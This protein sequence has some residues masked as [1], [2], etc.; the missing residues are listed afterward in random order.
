MLH[1]LPFKHSITSIALSEKAIIFPLLTSAIYVINHLLY[2]CGF[3]PRISYFSLLVSLSIPL[4]LSLYFNILITKY[5]N[6]LMYFRVSPP[7]IF[8]SFSQLW[9]LPE[10]ARTSLLSSSKKQKQNKK[11]TGKISSG[12]A[13]I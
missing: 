10:F 12:I 9:L 8:S 11:N 6:T 5:F 13:L 2:T 7:T 4:C 3:V 1:F